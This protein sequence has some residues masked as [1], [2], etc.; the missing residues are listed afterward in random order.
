MKNIIYIFLI[1]LYFQANAQV[2]TQKEIRI[3][4]A[5]AATDEASCKKIVTVLTPY[6][7]T[8]NPLWAGY[9]ACAI[10]MLANHVFN[11]YSKLSN[12]N[13]GKKLLEKCI[14]A[15]KGNIE[16]R[17]LRFA[18]QN[19]A[20]SFLGYNNSITEDKLILLNIIG[21]IKDSELKKN[22]I[23]YLKNCEFLTPTEK[24]KLN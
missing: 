4:Y 14:S 10:M 20:P 12:F 6:N 17:F 23:S 22:I 11:P 8:N 13:D 18:I 2:P 7:E 19:E 15:D 5:K 16:L 21:N 1:T 9:K 24:L 3:L